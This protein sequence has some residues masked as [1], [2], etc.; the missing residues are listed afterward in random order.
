MPATTIGSGLRLPWAQR[1]LCAV[2]IGAIVLLLWSCFHYGIERG[3]DAK[4]NERGRGHFMNAICS[5]LSMKKYGTDRY[6]CANAALES[7]QAAGLYYDDATLARIGKTLP[8]WLGDTAAMNHAIKTVFGEPP[9]PW[10]HGMWA[11][12]WGADA[13]YADFVQFAFRVFGKKLQAI[14]DGFFLLLAASAALFTAQFHRR[15]LALFTLAS[16]FYGLYVFDTTLID[17]F[18]VYSENSPR[19]L[20]LLALTPLLHAMFLILYRERAR[21]LTVALFVPQAALIAAAGDFRGLAYWTLIALGLWSGLIVGYGLW[22]RRAG[23]AELCRRCWPAAVG[24]V[25]LAIA[26]VIAMSSADPGI[27]DTGGMRLHTFWEPLYADLQYHPDWKR[28]Y[29]AEHQNQTGDATASVAVQQYRERHHLLDRPEDYLHG[30]R[31]LG[32]TQQGYEKYIRL[33]YLEFVANDPWFVITLK[34][35]DLW[36]LKEVLY[37]PF[38]NS[39][40]DMSWLFGTLAIVTVIVTVF[41]A[42][43]APGDFKIVSGAAATLVLFAI[44]A[45]GPVWVMVVD[46]DLLG[47]A[48]LMIFL[49]SIVAVFWLMLSA[50]LLI[51]AVAV[52]RGGPRALPSKAGQA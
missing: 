51:D 50:G 40:R 33:A 42:R 32:L 47:D 23:L 29:A 52:R 36:N 16:L 39:W 3:R 26:I 37:I 20:S 46:N 5:L 21:P 28:K 2:L 44:L 8:E 12:G 43:G 31:E 9:R 15:Y 4:L 35:H 22:R 27:A 18:Q 48:F 6:V 34:Y 41:H 17:N 49:A 11:I 13:G 24:A 14:Y 7:M 38:R 30:R 25:C 19:L 10:D 1:C 45:V